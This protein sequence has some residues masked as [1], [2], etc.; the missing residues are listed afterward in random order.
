MKISEIQNFL[1]N[2]Y[3][4]IGKNIKIK[5][6]N[7][8]KLNNQNL[9][10]SSKKKKFVLHIINEKMSTLQIEK[11]CK[12]LKF[13]YDNGANVQLPIKNAKGKF[14]NEKLPAYLTQYTVGKQSS[15]KNLELVNLAKSLSKLHTVFAKCKIVYPYKMNHSFY[16]ILNR[17]EIKKIKNLINKKSQNDK[18]DKNVLK[19]LNSLIT[20]IAK[21]HSYN[22]KLKS[23]SKQLIHFDIHPENVLFKNN[24]VVVFLDFNSIRK[25]NIW[26]DV[27]FSGFRFSLLINKQQKISQS[28]KIFI[29]SYLE[30]STN[31]IKF[32][33]MK[34]ILLLRILKNISYILKKHYFFNEKI[35][36]QEL[37][38]YFKF[39]KIALT[40][41]SN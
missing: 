27:V 3:S 22:L 14:V 9:L 29:Q 6:L 8:I 13:C 30:N 31:N 12:I 40:L 39:L 41:N 7:R 32:L 20:I 16:Q 34:N 15:G 36:I 25:G 19:N 1:Q 11:I 2:N 37:D 5:K 28:M 38:K 4:T 21:L 10:I 33:E 24:E 26:E 23:K 18:F 17:Q 35:Q